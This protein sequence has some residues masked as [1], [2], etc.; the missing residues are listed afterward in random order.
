MVMTGHNVAAAFTLILLGACQ[1]PP[2]KR[3]DDLA[4]LPDE[5]MSKSDYAR[6]YALIEL[7]T[8]EDLPFTTTHTFTLDT[9]RQVW[10]GVFTDDVEITADTPRI[11]LPSS[12]AIRIEALEDFPRIFHGGCHVVNLVA[13]AQTGETL[14]SWCNVDD[15][16]SASLSRVPYYFTENSP[17]RE[18]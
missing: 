2:H 12:G 17:L 18:N 11:P 10:V 13:D 3:V 5:A 1:P 4:V 9:P 15:R 14:A 6:F 7:K 8:D 16:P